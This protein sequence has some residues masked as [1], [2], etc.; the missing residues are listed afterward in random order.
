MP[1]NLTQQYLKAEKDFRSAASPDDELRCL[2][3]ML[4]ELPKHKGTDK[5]QAELKRKISKAKQ[6]VLDA[7][8]A[9]KSVGLR[10]PRQ[11]AGRVL[12]IGGPNAG[13][14]SLLAVLTRA[15]PEIGD[16]PFTT[17]EPSV[18]MMPWEDVAIQLIDT[19]PITTDYMENYMQGLIRGADLVW[20]VVDLGAD[21]GI[22]GVAELLQRLE[23]TKTR[24][25]DESRLD[26]ADIGLSYTKTFGVL[27]KSDASGF[28][29]RRDLLEELSP[30]SF[31]C[32]EVSAVSG[33]GKEALGE[34][35]FRALE[36]VRVYT[37]S[38]QRRDPD[39][40]KPFTVRRGQTLVDVAEMIHADLAH[41]FKFARIWSPGR[42][43][44]T[45]VKRDYIPEDRDIVEF[46]D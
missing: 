38:P 32:F 22:E 8:S 18:G 42:H 23:A 9:K 17:R 43:D 24:L 1:A 2:Q 21:E 13:K 19:P 39:M 36:V 14:S 16:F 20:L 5:L 12:M 45:R 37:K 15:K 44:G 27:N 10:I 31:D 41:R 28:A 7:R 3:V 34:A 4:R 40:E 26:N 25:G 11:G 30:I 6:D 46:N 33:R 29:A 35:T